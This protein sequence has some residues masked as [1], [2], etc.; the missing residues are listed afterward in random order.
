MPPMPWDVTLQRL[1]RD[2]PR[3]VQHRVVKSVNFKA[4]DADAIE[5]YDPEQ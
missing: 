4:Q 5:W 1:S 2:A 3:R